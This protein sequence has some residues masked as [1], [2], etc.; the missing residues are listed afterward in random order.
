MIKQLPVMDS[1]K[2]KMVISSEV[3]F[4]REKAMN[5]GW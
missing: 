5:D 1:A 4:E 3:G 2:G